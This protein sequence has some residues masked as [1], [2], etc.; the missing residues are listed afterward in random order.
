MQQEKT[1]KIKILIVEDQRQE[2]FQ[3]ERTLLKLG[4]EVVAGVAT[5]Q[6]A[7]SLCEQQPIDLVLLNLD[8]GEDGEGVA[9]AKKLYEARQLPII[10]YSN[11]SQNHYWEKIQAI[12]HFGYIP[13]PIQEEEL[14]L[15]I[16]AALH[17]L[18]MEA[19]VR[20]SEVEL[21]KANKILELFFSQS[22][23]G[24]FF[25]MS[26]QPVA[27]SDEPAQ[28]AAALGLLSQSLR[29][30]KLNDEILRQYKAS[31]EQLLGR[32]L[33][34]F[35]QHKPQ[36]G[37]AFLKELLNKKKTRY[38]H[39]QQQFDGSSIWVEGD[40]TVIYDY[41]LKVL[42]FLA[43]QRDITSEKLT[44]EA[45]MRSEANLK[46][47]FEN[48]VQAFTLID[49]DEQLS[50]RAFNPKANELAQLFVNQE[51]QL[52]QPAVA[53][54][55]EAFH[56]V[57]LHNV[58]RA[59]KGELLLYQK[60]FVV[61]GH[62]DLWLE[63][64]YVPIYDKQSNKVSQICYS[65]LDI[66]E[67]K[68]A[69]LKVIKSEQYYKNLI[70]NATDI[71]MVLD[72]RGVIT[73]TS[74]SASQ[75]LGYAE[76]EL[77][78]KDVYSFVCQEDIAKGKAYFW[79]KLK[80]DSVLP[81]IEVRIVQKNGNTRFIETQA[82]NLLHNP[83]VQGVIIISRDITERKEQEQSLLLMKRA[84]DA[85]QNGILI[86]DGQDTQKPII[87]VNDAFSEMT[88]YGTEEIIGRSMAL[89]YTP[90]PLDAAAQALPEEAPWQK[91]L[92]SD[93][94]S[95]FTLKQ[96]KKNGEAF[97]NETSLSPIFNRQGQLTHYVGIQNDVTQRIVYEELLKKIV[98]GISGEIGEAFFQ[99]L[100]KTISVALEVDFAYVGVV[101][102]IYPDQIQ[103]LAFC[104]N[105]QL[106][107]LES[108]SLRDSVSEQ[109]LKKGSVCVAEKARA[110]FPK[111]THLQ[112][113]QV[114][115]LIGVALKD[116]EER[117]IGLM[118]VA[119][120]QPIKHIKNAA[121]LLE[122]FAI[123]ASTELERSSTIEAL[124]KSQEKFRKLAVNSPDIIYI[125]EFLDNQTQRVIYLN[126]NTLFGYSLAEINTSG[127]VNRFVHPEDLGR[128]E[129]AITR[130][131]T[132]SSLESDELEYRVFDK[133]GV[134]EWVYRRH[135]V[136]ERSRSGKPK[137]LLIN[138][139][140]ITEKK[141]A[142]QELL[143]TNYELDSFVYRSSHDLRA[144]LRSILG[145]VNILHLEPHPQAQKEY[146][147]LIEKSVKK[148][149]SFIADM[150]D[151]S[152]NSRL[153]MEAKAIDFEQLLKD[154]IE[155]LQ[156]MEKAPKI[157][158]EQEI[159][160]KAPFYS[161]NKR[162]SILFQNLLSNAIK[163]HNFQQESPFVKVSVRDSLPAGIEVCFQ[164][165]GQGIQDEHLLR[166]F[167]MFYRANSEAQGSGLGLYIVAQV[168]ERLKGRIEVASIFGQGSTFTL[169]LPSLSP[170]S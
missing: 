137:Q 146:L 142:E 71:I 22:L 57:F 35:F 112:V 17:R 79:G 31:R 126:R 133:K 14:Q 9:T 152:R 64:S 128:L 93:K 131:F 100:V 37:D 89:L 18:Q 119:H 164:D 87:Y 59:K 40:Y 96:Y 169:Y 81:P 34:A 134:E 32:N 24:A 83:H 113:Q 33:A 94:E 65:G 13:K 167:D 141:E 101:S 20:H 102:P 138:L 27:W 120:R 157:R 129:A 21:D 67:R 125:S 88:G 58:E 84:V 49:T 10:F 42:G 76:E 147:D 124:Q 92:L 132:E 23:E 70:K 116:S 44:K 135:T 60:R 149:D 118:I 115:S 127:F 151:F 122:I 11:H 6:A 161:D 159:S 48:S 61:Q 145:L 95:R 104:Q 41:D 19:Q 26:E 156:Y 153:E 56:E 140:L 43:L 74:P 1:L 121:T 165:N 130:L 109:V 168:V 25:M 30:S 55:P 46:A 160:L 29:I 78:G 158:I 103:L 98:E 170:S 4:H 16:E 105:Q 107:E 2:A 82:T 73:Y 106:Q 136:M 50:V 54:L 5:M 69:E 66:T 155:N 51:I 144:P 36:E 117:A 39:I 148:L 91:A 150:T 52:H 86:L 15:G 139:T 12:P 110:L 45:L 80:A 154:T 97:F 28:Q 75:M 47:I 72:A 143:K 8:L 108:Y 166:I 162:L 77:L 163:Y 3:I 7:L 85:S 62:S 90:Q 99:S 63:V 111:D 114:E 68:K 53:Y 38:T 123:R